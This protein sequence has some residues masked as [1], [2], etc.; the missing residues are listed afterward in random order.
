MLVRSALLPGHLTTT[1][2]QQHNPY[3]TLASLKALDAICTRG[4]FDLGLFKAFA[5]MGVHQR[6]KLLLVAAVACHLVAT[7][8]ASLMAIDL[9]S[10][11]LKVSLIKPGRTP[12]SV[13]VN[14]MSKRK[15]PALVGMI[16]EDRLLGEEAFSF[17]IRYPD[18]IFSRTRNLLGRDP[19]DP[20]VRQL[21]SDQ[22]LPY[23]IE[24][25]P[26]SKLIALKVNSTTSFTVE[27]LVVGDTER[28]I[29]NET[30]P[31]F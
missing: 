7:C 28:T 20:Y 22:Y 5:A 4:R 16:G 11:F 23:Q 6:F 3:Q 26:L 25:H 1:I 13:V 10:E 24:R 21:L 17:A 29:G 8:A 19:E 14:E 18:L 9:G 12:I 27:E 2:P 30:L 15:A 31:S